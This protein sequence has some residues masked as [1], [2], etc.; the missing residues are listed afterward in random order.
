MSTLFITLIIA[1]VLVV[2]AIA[3]L[4]VGWLFSGKSRIVRGACGMDPNKVKQ[5]GCGT[6]IKCELCEDDK[7][8]SVKK[9]DKKEEKENPQK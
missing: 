7:E 3:S 6:E 8:E 5:K 4:S 1:F 2:L 9:N